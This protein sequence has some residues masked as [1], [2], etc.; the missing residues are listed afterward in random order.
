MNKG[1]GTGY[2]GRPGT[3]TAKV[4]DMCGGMSKISV[5]CSWFVGRLDVAGRC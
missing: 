2:L 1:L 5:P 4:V 3:T